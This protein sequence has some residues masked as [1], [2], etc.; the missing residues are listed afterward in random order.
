MLTD[1]EREFLGAFIYEATTDL[2]KGPATEDLHRRGVYYGDITFLMTAYS[3]EN[4]RDQENFGGKH[5]PDPMA[6][7]W[8]D[9]ESA[10]RR[11][12]EMERELAKSRKK[13]AIS[14]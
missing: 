5:N 6:C 9:R 10:V 14:S 13:K 4:P 7:P 12:Q 2:F 1:Q 11:D 8:S 3:L